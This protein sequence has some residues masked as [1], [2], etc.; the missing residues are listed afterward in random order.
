MPELFSIKAAGGC[1]KAEELF[2]VFGGRNCP[3]ANGWFS[4]LNRRK[5]FR[6]RLSSLKSF[7]I[8]A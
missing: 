3:F 1:V 2:S 6:V 5:A 8:N 4:I 7:T